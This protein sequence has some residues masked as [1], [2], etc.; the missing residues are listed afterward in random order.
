MQ[1]DQA[2][3][4]VMMIRPNDFGY[5]PETADSNSF[6]QAEGKED[7]REIRRRALDEFNGFIATLKAAGVEVLEFNSADGVSPPDAVFPNNWV[8]FHPDGK[9]IIYP[10]M[11][12]SRR[13][14][15]RMDIV[16]ALEKQCFFEVTEIIDLTHYELEELYLEGTGSLVFDYQHGMLFA[17]QSPRTNPKLVYK[18]SELL[19]YRPFLFEAVDD[20]GQD[21]YHTNVM[22]C[23]A[24]N[25]AV[26]CLDAIANVHER[27][28]LQQL[29]SD[30]GHDIINITRKQMNHFAGNMM[31]LKNSKKQSVL[32]MSQSAF[33]SLNKEQIET[34]KQ[35]SSIVSSSIDTIEKYG[36]GSARCMMAGI[37]LPRSH[38]YS[39]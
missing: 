33:D 20:L 38:S 3:V 27:N 6:Q 12:E 21:I 7:I 24:E 15:R 39:K 37:H 19:G 5:N 16:T 23:I 2:P 8:S 13:L 32:A 9:V 17:N 28:T 10:M 31:E 25:Y 4:A 36:G 35:Y 18:V 30:S 14:E 11:A 29:L 26:V 1:I 22:M 34:I